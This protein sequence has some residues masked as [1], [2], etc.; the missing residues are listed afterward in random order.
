MF[1]PNRRGGT[2]ELSDKS[3]LEKVARFLAAQAW[4]REIQR[5][6]TTPAVPQTDAQQRTRYALEASE[7]M[8]RRWREY[9]GP[10]HLLSGV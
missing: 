1:K 6:S 8:D 2:I 3:P 10:A 4:S 5:P 7:Y 9:I